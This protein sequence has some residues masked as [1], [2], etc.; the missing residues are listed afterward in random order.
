MIKK[1][2]TAIFIAAIALLLSTGGIIFA[3]LTSTLNINGGAEFNPSNWNVK[4]TGLV[5]KY[6]TG[7][8]TGTTPSLSA[9][10]VGTYSVVLKGPGDKVVYKFDVTNSGSLD[11]VLATYTKPSPICTA[12][13]DANDVDDEDLICDNLVYTLN[14]D[15][16]GDPLVVIN[17]TLESLQTRTLVLTIEYPITM[18]TVP[19]DAVTIEFPTVTLIYEQE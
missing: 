6:Q 4:F 16:F 1:E 17:D 12:T 13:G 15:E 5:S 10:T 7:D 8:A 9:T 18:L 3:A 19:A 11:A 2:K 14:Y